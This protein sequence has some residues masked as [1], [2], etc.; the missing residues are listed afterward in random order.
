MLVVDNI[1]V[2]LASLSACVL[3]TRSN[4]V[5]ARLYITDS[6]V[7]IIGCGQ[8]NGLSAGGCMA[9]ISMH[10]LFTKLCILPFRELAG[11]VADAM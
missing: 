3:Q 11:F 5:W 9:G 7:R 8:T 2:L 10:A 6:Y 4:I 1:M